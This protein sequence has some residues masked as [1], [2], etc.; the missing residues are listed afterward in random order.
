MVRL[1]IHAQSETCFS[2]FFASQTQAV[3]TTCAARPFRAGT[4]I[5]SKDQGV[6]NGKNQIRNM[7]D[8]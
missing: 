8:S 6:C 3:D 5:S 1:A 2:P 7:A 4:G